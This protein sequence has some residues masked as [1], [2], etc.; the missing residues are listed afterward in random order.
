MA[1]LFRSMNQTQKFS[2]YSQ[3]FG[4]FLV[5]MA[6]KYLE[7]TKFY[8]DG[9]ELIAAI[10]RSEVINI[11]EFKTTTPLSHLIKV[12][13]QLETIETKLGKTLVLNHIMQ[14]AGNNLQRDDIGKLITQFPFANWQEAFGD[15]T[16]NERNVKND[17]LAIERGEMPQVSPSDE[18][19]YVLKQVSKR[20]KERDFGLLAP[21]VQDMYSQYE[22]YHLDKQA[23]EA[24]AVKAAQAEFIP[25][26]GA[27]VAADMYVPDG[28][29]NKTPKRVRVPY[30]ALD[31]LLKQL[32]QQGM[33]QDAMQQMN[34]AQVAEV[35]GMLLGQNAPQDGQASPQGVM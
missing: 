25:T 10:G 13:D 7:L 3:K 22:Q 6:E 24:Q 5:E 19:S 32:Q 26:G 4:E 20:K 11:A 1:M 33:T 28:D 29:P 30:Q 27:M 17:F 14:Y 15:F 8:L 23:Q 16:I 31:W 2:F 18:S 21:Q 35:A 12:E 34:Q 9:D